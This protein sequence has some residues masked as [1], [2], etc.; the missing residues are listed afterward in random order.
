L[1]KAGFKQVNEIAG[2]MA[3]WEAAKLSVS[4]PLS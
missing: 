2:G 4:V 1:Q 3:A